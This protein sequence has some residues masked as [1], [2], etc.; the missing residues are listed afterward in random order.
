VIL[1]W[2]S[3]AIA[4]DAVEV[5]SD[6]NLVDWGRACQVVESLGYPVDPIWVLG[7]RVWEVKSQ[8]GSVFYVEWA[9]DREGLED[10]LAKLYQDGLIPLAPPFSFSG[11]LAGFPLGEPL[12]DGARIYSVGVKR[13]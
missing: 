12:W 2:H 1:K 11:P 10:W 7:R 5:A 8:A 9:E 3:E 4:L 6:G 13:R